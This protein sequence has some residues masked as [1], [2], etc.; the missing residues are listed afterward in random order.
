[1]I[2]RSLI[3][4]GLVA[5]TPVLAVAGPLQVT[6][7]IQLEKRVAAA[8][9][10]TR[11]TLVPA[12]HAVPGD[13]LTVTL[14]YRNTGAQPIANLVLA[15]PVPRGLLYRGVPSGTAAPELSV[16]GKNFGPLS[17]LRVPA[18]GGGMRAAGPAD[19]TSVRWRLSSPVAAG[20]SG[21]FAFQA[22]LK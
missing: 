8:D 12:D 18:P 1:M 20:S 3:V 11:V 16:D 15:N 22:V 7:R 14:A 5:V 19:V 2:L 21:Q 9:G 6:S 13:R 10:T 4:T 17:A